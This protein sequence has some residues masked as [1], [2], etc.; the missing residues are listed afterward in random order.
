[1]SSRLSHS[2]R[3]SSQ[4][5]DEDRRKMTLD[6]LAKTQRVEGVGAGEHAA[7]LGILE[8]QLLRDGAALRVAKHRGRVD[9]E[10]LEQAR[11]VSGELRCRVRRR[12]PANLS[13][14]AQVW[15]IRRCRLAQ[16]SMT[17]SNI[18]PVTMSPCTSR[19]GG[20]DPRSVK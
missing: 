17:G 19:S 10:M 14:T 12:K 18:S 3:G 15:T 1:M 13:V 20:P 6:L 9:A 4:D 5:A 16:C 8:S 7:A 11:Q 2:C